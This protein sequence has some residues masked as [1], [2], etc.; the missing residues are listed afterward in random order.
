[1]L[2]HKYHGVQKIAGRFENIM[3]LAAT[4]NKVE[5]WIYEDVYSSYVDDEELRKRL[6]ENNPYA[7]MDILEHMMEYY[8]RGYWDADKE[9]IDKIK[10]LYLEMED[11]IEENL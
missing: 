2:E 10:E 8:N 4:T 11:Q 9:Q 6:V 5:E 3:G 7:Y 1:M